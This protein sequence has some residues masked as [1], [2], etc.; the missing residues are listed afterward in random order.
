MPTNISGGMTMAVVP[1]KISR[2]TPGAI[3]QPQPPPWDKEVKRGD[4]SGVVFGITHHYKRGDKVSA[5]TALQSTRAWRRKL[6]KPP[7]NTNSM[8]SASITAVTSV[9]WCFS[10]RMV[11]PNWRYTSS[12]CW[13]SLAR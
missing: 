7:D 11:V 13:A 12:S 4:G 1:C 8:A 10:S 9:S 3:L 6:I 5:T 2:S